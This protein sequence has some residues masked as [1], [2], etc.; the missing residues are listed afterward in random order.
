M[1]DPQNNF[2]ALLEYAS[3]E[4]LPMF[5]QLA[6]MMPVKN[7]DIDH[8]QTYI[9]SW[10]NITVETYSSDNVVALS[11]K[12]FRCLVTP[13]PWIAYS[14]RYT[15]ARLRALGF[16]VLDDVVD[17]R[18]DRLIEAHH[19]ISA[20]MDTACATIDTLKQHDWAILSQRCRTAAVH[21][22]QQL[23]MMKSA[24]PADF[25]AWLTDRI[26]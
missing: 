16:D 10:L 4:E 25:A 1:T 20:F 26:T 9:H 22:Q 7:Y 13:V 21:N 3:V 6:N 17:H 8:E 19:K 14:G 5:Y 23:A 18:Y 15:I 24:W 11:E 2:H 12:I